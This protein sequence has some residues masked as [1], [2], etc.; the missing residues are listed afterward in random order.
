MHEK[1]SNEVLGAKTAQ[2]KEATQRREDLQEEMKSMM[3][4]FMESFKVTLEA[5][6]SESNKRQIIDTTEAANDNPPSEK[7]RDDRTTPMKLFP[8]DKDLRDPALDLDAM[9]ADESIDQSYYLHLFRPEFLQH[10]PV[11]RPFLGIVSTR[12]GA[13]PKDDH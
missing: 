3:Q 13:Q 2:S 10:L 11:R 9:V 5:K 12:P 8:K 6:M 7:R 4:Q 1:R